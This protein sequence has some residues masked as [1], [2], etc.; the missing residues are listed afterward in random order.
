MFRATSGMLLIAALLASPALAQKRAVTGPSPLI[1]A[2]ERCRALSDAAQRLSCYDSAAGNLIA[3][4]QKGE[5][6]VVDRGQ[7][8]QARQSLFGFG[9]IKIPFL[10]DNEQTEEITTTVRTARAIGNGKFRIVLADGNAVWE[11]TE[12]YVNFH[13]PEPGQT[14]VIKRG[15]LGSYLLRIDG[16]RGVKGRRVG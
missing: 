11:T 10:N 2:L 15:P 4:T 1:G 9:S 3:A 16:Q 7:L 14:V 12:S 13:D 6:S 5:V 8:R